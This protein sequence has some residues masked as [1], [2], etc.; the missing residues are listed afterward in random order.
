MNV[1][2]QA[3]TYFQ[4]ASKDGKNDSSLFCLALVA[5]E[6]SEWK[7]ASHY[8]DQLAN[9]S[10]SS[11]IRNLSA[12]FSQT[13][14]RSGEIPH[15]SPLVA[16]LLSTFI[17]GGGQ[18]YSGHYVDALQAFA[19]VASFSF[20][21]YLAYQHDKSSSSNYLLTAVS[22]SITGLFHLGN[23]IGAERTATYYNQRQRD[24]FLQ[25]IR[26]KSNDVFN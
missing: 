24:I 3:I 11:E 4:D 8:Y 5:V 20:A 10:L 17:P 6:M 18:V 21:S 15:K 16:G 25:E 12:E 23:I 14:S 7:T 22:V 1:P 13:L 9:K 26:Q 2:P 19:F